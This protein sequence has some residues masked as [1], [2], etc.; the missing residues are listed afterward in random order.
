MRN[1]PPSSDS[2][3][4]ANR[5]R[6]VDFVENDLGQA[7]SQYDGATTV[8]QRQAALDRVH[9]ALR[10]LQ[11]GNQQVAW[12]P[13]WDLQSAVNDLFNQPN[14]DVTADVNI[15][16]PIFDQNLVT[17]GPVYRKGYW[18]Q[19]TAGPKTGFGL[20]PSDDGIAFY[21]SQLL[22]SVTPITDF[23]RQIASDPR[24]A[25]RRSSTSS[26]RRPWTRPSSRS[27]RSCG[28]RDWRPRL[29]KRTAST[30]RSARPPSRAEDSAAWSPA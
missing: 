12:Q 6:W 7:L 2:T 18:S 8:V 5:Q 19:V 14:L 30:P 11:T 4:V 3:V 22:T 21:N 10:S 25:G 29:R 9:K 15:V 13:S 26:R 20:L 17:T 24:A 16:S 1:L 27:T 28:P 23:Q